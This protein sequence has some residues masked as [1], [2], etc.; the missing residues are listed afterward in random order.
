[1][2]RPARPGVR[3]I[4]VI[5]LFLLAI[6][7]L[8]GGVT[9]RLRLPGLVSTAHLVDAL[10]IFGGL[11]LLAGVT[12]Q[13]ANAPSRSMATVLRLAVAG[14]PVLL[15]QLALG[16]YVRHSGTGLA[17]PDFP[18]CAGQVLPAHVVGLAP[19]THRWLGVA[20]LGLFLHLALVARG[21][22]A[23]PI[24]ATA[25]ALAVLQ[26]GLGIAAVL[27]RL[28]PAVRAAHAAVGYALWGAA[29]WLGLRSGAW[30]RLV[31]GTHRG[32]GAFGEAAHA[33]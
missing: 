6:Q 12:G 8:L 28:E 14:T 25:A 17:C 24:A 22:P 30:D 23:A 1:M 4:G 19:W 11:L 27:L 29:V 32:G 33:S 10:L 7:I 26:I 20:L 15:I 18:L 5:L 2:R 13:A 16:G 31:R 9:V 3:R 21:T